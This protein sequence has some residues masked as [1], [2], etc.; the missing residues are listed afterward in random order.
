MLDDAF[1]V[2][3]LPEIDN[4]AA[5][6]FVSQYGGHWVPWS[7]LPEHNVESALCFD[8]RGSCLLSLADTKLK[9]VRANF[10]EGAVNHR[11]QFGGGKGQMIAKAV[12]IKGRCLPQVLD[13]TAGLGRDGFVLATLGCHITLL[14]RSPVIAQLLKDGLQEALDNIDTAGIVERIDLRCV[15][16]IDYLS[17]PE[18]PKVDVVYLDPMFPHREKSSLV[19]KEMRLFRSLVGDDLD[20]PTLLNAALQKAI[21]RVVVKRPRKAPI[22]EGKTPSFSLEGKS[23]RFDIYTLRSME[24]W[25]PQDT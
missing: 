5:L 4:A 21:Y 11:R 8:D 2:T 17:L 6:A 10:I 16:S 25:I 13:A 19:K 9:P 3:A 20:A 7:E 15:S 24:S 22:I 14:E 18:T 23:S 12:G 1:I